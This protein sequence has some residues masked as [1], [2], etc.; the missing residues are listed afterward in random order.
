MTAPATGPDG[1]TVSFTATATDLVDG[2]VPVTCVP[3][4]GG[5]LPGETTV[6]CTAVIKLEA[7]RPRGS[8]R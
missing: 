3:A 5:Y 8:F 2:S 4:S 6:S 7:I 1:A